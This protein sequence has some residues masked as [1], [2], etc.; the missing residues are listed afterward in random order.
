ML[1]CEGYDAPV[2]S[3]E[4]QLLRRSIRLHPVIYRSFGLSASGCGDGDGDGDGGGG[5]VRKSGSLVVAWTQEEGMNIWKPRS[6][7]YHSIP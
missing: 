3:L 5:H 2:G 7:S 1:A 4:R 6:T